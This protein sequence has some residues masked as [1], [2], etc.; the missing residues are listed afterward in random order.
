[1]GD[2]LFAECTHALTTQYGLTS[3]LFLGGLVGSLT[4]CTGMCAPFVLA[5]TQ[6]GPVLA[7]P[8]SS[9][10]LPYHLGRMTTYVGLGVLVHSVV[11]LAYLFSDA[12]SLITAPLLMLAG[13]LF[14]VS[15]FPSL[16][17][18][19]PWAGNIRLPKI[20]STL[21]A[22]THGLVQAQDFASR[23]V[24]GLL[25]G[26]IPCGLVLAAL[27]AAATAPDMGQAALAIA[28]FAVGT[29]LSLMII[30]LCGKGL[31]Q[32]FPVFS[33]YFSRIA[34]TISSLWLF[35]LAGRLI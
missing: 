18:L 25:L 26:F 5:Q 2:S 29:M 22:K 24:L 35:I 21:T 9:L 11:N 19:F 4:H 33:Q 27:M 16:T 15:A 31:K 32:K 17:A 13:V 23:Y 14:L 7:K 20:F 3:S 8:S 12:R 1:M 34:M 30:G 10:L 6:A 28:A